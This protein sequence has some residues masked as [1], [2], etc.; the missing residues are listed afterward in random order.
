MGSP[1]DRTH[2][3]YAELESAGVLQEFGSASWLA[4]DGGELK[5]EIDLPLAAVSLV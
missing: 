4:L 5:V 3:Q 2:R 1:Q